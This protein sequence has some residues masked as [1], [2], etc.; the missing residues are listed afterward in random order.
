M[1]GCEAKTNSCKE[2]QELTAWAREATRRMDKQEDHTERQERDIR[3]LF[4]NQAG[5][6]VYVTQILDKIEGLDTKIFNVLTTLAG[7]TKED[8]N[9]DR[10][11]RITST[12][13]WLEAVKYIILITT[14]ALITYLFTSRGD[15]SPATAVV[16]YF[17]RRG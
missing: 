2:I 11:E 5:T 16:S 10:A 6:K 13:K 1:D 12:D 9:A 17:V 4:E 8:R 15:S 14:A 3:I 7:D